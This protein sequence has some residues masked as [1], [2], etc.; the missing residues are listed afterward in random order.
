VIPVE[1]TDDH[2]RERHAAFLRRV[3]D[4]PIDLLFLG[5]SITRR[6]AEV[7]ALWERHYAR[8]NAANFG[9]GSDTT[10]SLLWRL[11]NGEI[12]GIAP[13]AAVLLIGTND[14]GTL[15][16]AAIVD[17]VREIL[18]VMREKLPR[19]RV[20]LLAVFPRSDGMD[21]VREVNAGLAALDDGAMVRFLD[22]GSEFLRTDGSL[23]AALM[24]DGIHL[25]E[26][27]YVKWAAAMEPLLASL[28]GPT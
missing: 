10:G 25:V 11:L 23:D 18:R 21:T 17:G 22:M 13:L 6:W 27:G 5:D 2:F 12:S 1:R 14:V 8:R 28:L 7:P 4:G 20:L 26:P 3:H 15:P 19:T 16:A 24:P 9:V